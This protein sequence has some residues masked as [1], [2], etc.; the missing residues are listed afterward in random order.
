MSSLYLDRKHLSIET[1]AGSLTIRQQGEIKQHIPLNL[2][3]R[4]VVSVGI[5]LNTHT[6]T[7][8]AHYGISLIFISGRSNSQSAQIIATPNGN[9]ARRL[10]QYKIA[11]HPNSVQLIA[12]TI[13]TAKIRQQRHL[14]KRAKTLR[15]DI[16]FA[17]TKGINSLNDILTKTP[18][19]QSI[20]SLMGYEGA[21]ANV[22][23]TA[24]SQLFAESLG[25]HG[26]AKRPPT[27]PV[28]ACLS[29]GYT[30]LHHEAVRIVTGAGLDP[31]L[32]FVHQPAYNRESLA[33]DL[34]EPHRAH[35]DQMIWRLF[36]EKTLRDYHFT[37]R[38]G[39][40][41]L[42]K[43]GRAIFYPIYEARVKSLRRLMRLQTYQLVHHL[44][45]TGKSL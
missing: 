6:L 3:E 5:E 22:Y 13:I 32:G 45:Q 4:I 9:V 26:R 12:N 24:Y 31:Y 40:Y 1:N 19:A 39:G 29:L 15:H 28:N 20:D 18:N 42:T 16:S 30:L 17:L 7:Q 38:D 2:L 41:Y 21:A 23:F 34:I 37:Q 14:L 10:T 8:L 36:A 11:Q 33:S 43:E 44:E 35:I 25:F 27:D